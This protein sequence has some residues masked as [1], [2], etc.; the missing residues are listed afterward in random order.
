MACKTY[1]VV[2]APRGVL[3]VHR[4]GSVVEDESED[5]AIGLMDVTGVLV[6]RASDAVAESEAVC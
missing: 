2:I 6:C 5:G 4:R 3:R 1:E